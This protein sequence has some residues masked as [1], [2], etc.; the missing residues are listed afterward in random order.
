MPKKPQQTKQKDDTTNLYVIPF[1]PTKANVP[2]RK[3]GKPLIHGKPHKVGKTDRH[4]VEYRVLEIE[5]DSGMKGKVL[6]FAKGVKGGNELEQKIHAKYEQHKVFFQKPFSGYTEF[7]DIPQSDVNNII[8][9]IQQ[10]SGRYTPSVS[11]E[12]WNKDFTPAN[13][14]VIYL[15]VIFI[16]AFFLVPLL[17]KK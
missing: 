16:F 3:G 15:I 2:T 10:A 7:L 13:M 17:F 6:H 12:N 8:Q 4:K 5:K 1:T 9:E 14:K 11:N